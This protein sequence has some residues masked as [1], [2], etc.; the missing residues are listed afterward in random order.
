MIVSAAL[1]SLTFYQVRALDSSLEVTGSA[2][3][4][5]TSD[6]VKWTT[7]FTR[8]AS[9]SQLKTG[10]AQLAGDLK[11]VQK[12]FHDNGIDEKSITISTVSLEQQYYNNQAPDAE[13]H[14]TLR[15]TVELQSNEVEKV[16]ALAKNIQPLVDAGVLFTT[17]GLEYYYSKLPEVR[18]ELLGDAVKDAQE[19]ARIIAQSGGKRVGS[20]K[21]ASVGVVQVLPVNSV[22]IEDYGAYDTSKIEK[23]IMVTVRTTFGLR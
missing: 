22:S 9:A 3:K 16:T 11:Q 8:Q 23:E 10:Y 13:L 20:L 14:Y 18:V 15:Q 7:S 6:V 12:F 4:Q 2:R 21:A 17:G 5:V 19:R 1:A